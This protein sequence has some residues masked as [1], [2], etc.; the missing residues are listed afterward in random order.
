MKSV[1]SCGEGGKSDSGGFE[2]GLLLSSVN[3]TSDW[4]GTKRDVREIIVY[5][6]NV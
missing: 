3:N 6:T 4:E 5:T 2:S 1:H